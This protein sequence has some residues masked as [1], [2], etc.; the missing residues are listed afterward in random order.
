MG[1]DGKGEFVNIKKERK[2][3][4]VQYA[5]LLDPTIQ[6]IDSP[7]LKLILIG[8]GLTTKSLNFKFGDNMIPMQL[9]MKQL[10]LLYNELGDVLEANICAI[11]IFLSNRKVKYVSDLLKDNGEWRKVDNLIS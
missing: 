8:W 5:L 10:L 11:K 4:S 1:M 9:T 7:T 3:W 2:R 6:V